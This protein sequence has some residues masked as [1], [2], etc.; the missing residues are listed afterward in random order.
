ML[1]RN[2]KVKATIEA[3]KR[4]GYGAEISFDG[5]YTDIGVWGEASGYKWALFEVG[6]HAIVTDSSIE[7][8]IFNITATVYEDE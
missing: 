3:V 2:E 6:E 4:L 8:G 1:T 7:D 5:N